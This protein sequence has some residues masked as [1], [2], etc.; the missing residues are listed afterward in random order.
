VTNLRIVQPNRWPE[1]DEENSSIEVA[2]A[3]I[4]MQAKAI[5]DLVFRVDENF[6]AAVELISRCE[7][8][9]VVCGIGKSGHVARKLAATFSCSGTKSYFLHAGEAAHGDLGA[10]A[11]T[12]IAVLIS[13]SGETYEVVRLIPFLR[14]MGVPIISLVGNRDS[15]IARNSDCALDVAIEREVCPLDLTPTTSTLAAM[16]MGDAL[17]MAV[18]RQRDFSKAD[19]R[20]YHPAG[21]L[22][23]HLGGKVRDAMRRHLLPTCPPSA[24]V[25]DIL[26]KMSSG[27]LGLVVVIGDS[28]NPIGLLTDSDLRRALQRYEDVLAVPVHSI[29]NKEPVTVHESALLR[30]AREKMHRLRLKALLVVDSED[31]LIGVLEEAIDQKFE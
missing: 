9:L 4:T 21:S 1:A 22:G 2:K 27:H 8:R 16:A 14:E 23:R 26:A 20:R 7:G 29:M 15:T 10:I 12:D 28:S 31:K 25:R 19:F 17:A 13:N 5:A 11:K 18:M 30:D 3:S 24:T 6:G